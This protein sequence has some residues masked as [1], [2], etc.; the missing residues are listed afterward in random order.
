MDKIADHLFVF[1]GKGDI[2][3]FPGNYTGYIQQQKEQQKQSIKTRKETVEEK[4][5]RKEKNRPRK[6]SFKEKRE[7]EQV[8]NEIEE[9][10]KEKAVL[11]N[12]INSGNLST[13]VLIS[14]SEKLGDILTTI[15]EKETRWLE[16]KDIEDN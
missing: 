11:E 4:P 9:L 16:L 8:E 15:D 12:E 5:K 2:K 14:K 1:D 13:D 7:L 6:L 3:D 10:E